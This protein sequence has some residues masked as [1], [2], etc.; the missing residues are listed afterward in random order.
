MK[1]KIGDKVFNRQNGDILKITNISTDTC[2][3]K[4]IKSES[5]YLI[6]DNFLST[7]GFIKKNYVLLKKNSDIEFIS[8]SEYEKEIQ[9]KK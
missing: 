5:E 1:F 9:S 3:F 2:Y 7:I 6:N 4:V 8:R